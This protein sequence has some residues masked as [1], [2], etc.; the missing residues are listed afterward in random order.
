[1]TKKQVEGAFHW[2][3]Y[4]NDELDATGENVDYAGEDWDNCPS[5]PIVSMPQGMSGWV[6]VVAETILAALMFTGLLVMGKLGWELL[7]WLARL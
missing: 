3:D 2:R 1:M 5:G 6:R 7:T 4:T